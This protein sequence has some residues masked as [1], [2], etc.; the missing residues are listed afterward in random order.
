MI[1]L[2]KN[3]LTRAHKFVFVG[4]LV[5]F[6][7]LTFLITNVGVDDGPGHYASVFFTTMGT[8]TGPLTGAIS[9]G[10]QGCCL[11]FSLTVMAYCAPFLLIGLA[12]QFVRLPDRKWLRVVRICVW[13]VGWLVWF[14]GGLLSFGHALA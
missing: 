12:A 10:F 7:V 1:I 14:L 13:T 11:R 9:R 5:V 3:N 2:M 4:M 6:M 8:I